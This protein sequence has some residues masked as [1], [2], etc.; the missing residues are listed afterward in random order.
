MP[1]SLNETKVLV[2][3]ML[4]PMILTEYYDNHLHISHDPHF[5]I[6]TQSIN[7]SFFFITEYS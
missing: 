7:G 5:H 1:K 4:R 3:T 2:T 6:N